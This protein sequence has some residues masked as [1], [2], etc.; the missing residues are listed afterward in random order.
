MVVVTHHLRCFIHDL[1]HSLNDTIRG[2][3]YRHLILSAT[4][5]LF[6]YLRF[7]GVLISDIDQIY[8]LS[9][10]G[11]HASTFKESFH[12]GQFGRD[13]IRNPA[14]NVKSKCFLDSLRIIESKVILS[15]CLRLK[16]SDS[17]LIKCALSPS[18]PRIKNTS[19][20]LIIERSSGAH[21]GPKNLLSDN[22]S[23]ATGNS[24]SSNKVSYI[25]S[26]EITVGRDFTHCVKHVVDICHVITSYSSLK[27]FLCKHPQNP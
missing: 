1:P 19:S 21:K 2:N 24:V 26:P 12:A 15:G 14:L 23:K 6:L 10:Q 18:N 25:L 8:K 20:E 11:S 9:V 3:I 5:R 16:L 27:G 4:D 13:G 7:D 22:L 17:L